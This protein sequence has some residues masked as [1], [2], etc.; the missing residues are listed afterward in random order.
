MCSIKY[1]RFLPKKGKK[2]RTNCLINLLVSLKNKIVRT[3]NF[4][5]F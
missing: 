5:D 2:K 4:G 1:Y 3:N